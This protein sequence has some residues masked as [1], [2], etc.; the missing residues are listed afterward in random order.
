MGSS[1]QHRVSPDSLSSLFPYR[2]YYL[3]KIMFLEYHTPRSFPDRFLLFSDHPPEF[4]LFIRTTPA[5]KFTP[6]RRGF[7]IVNPP[8]FIS[9]FIARLHCYYHLCDAMQVSFGFRQFFIQLYKNLA[10]QTGQ[11]RRWRAPT[12]KEQ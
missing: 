2:R 12:M 11:Y 3:S 1:N 4:P 6:Y 9:I 5:V 10:A 7:P 8:C